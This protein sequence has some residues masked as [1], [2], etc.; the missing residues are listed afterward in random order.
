MKKT[1][2]LTAIFCLILLATATAMAQQ[3]GNYSMRY[4]KKHALLSHEGET[5]VVNVD[6]EW[7]EAMDGAE[8]LPLQAYAIKLLFQQNNSDLDQ[9]LQAFMSGY[10]EEV[11]QQFDALPDDKRVCYVDIEMR[12]LSYTPGRYVTFHLKRSVKPASQSSQEASDVHKMVTYDLQTLKPL[13][14]DD[15]LR[16]DRIE[17]SFTDFEILLPEDLLQERIYD[18]SVNDACLVNDQLKFFPE[19]MWRYLTKDARAMLKPQKATSSSSKKKSESKGTSQVT[20]VSNASQPASLLEPDGV[21]ETTQPEFQVPDVTLNEYL[22][23]SVRSVK[24]EING[25]KHGMV[26]AMVDV[27]AQG[28]TTG[29]RI[30]LPLAAAYD[31]EVARVVRGLPRWKPAI[32]NGEPVATQIAIAFEF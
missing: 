8:L 6:M 7:P 5:N 14:R 31:R 25:V 9:S 26:M 13:S 4:V 32:R 27:D 29:T 15:I 22:T 28:W 10:G 21:V 3:K 2:R 30:V 20:S 11:Q 1:Y 24:D 16:H 23:R 17:M 18:L 12:L 19:S